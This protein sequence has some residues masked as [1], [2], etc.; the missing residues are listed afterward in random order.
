VR[1][2]GGGTVTLEGLDAGHRLGIQLDGV[3]FDDPASIQ[4]RAKHAEVTAGP[5]AFNLNVTGTDV[6]VSGSAGKSVKN[7]C[8]GK[9]AD[10]PLR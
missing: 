10:F 4:V 6:T 7:A 8:A 3:L 5:G 1:V 2:E 9:F